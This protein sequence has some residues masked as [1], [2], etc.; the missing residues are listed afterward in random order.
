MTKTSLWSGVGGHDHPSGKSLRAVCVC[1]CARVGDTLSHFRW[2]RVYCTYYLPSHRYPRG[3]QES[4]ASPRKRP[5]ER[6]TWIGSIQAR[7][8]Q[9]ACSTGLS[10]HPTPPHPC[11]VDICMDTYAVT[12]CCLSLPALREASE[13]SQGWFS[14]GNGIHAEP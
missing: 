8:S 13:R 5:K 6:A 3:S 14:N 4:L 9:A 10:P 2:S 1:V 7:E 12:T 11:R